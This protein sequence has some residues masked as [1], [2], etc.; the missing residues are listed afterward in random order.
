M[1]QSKLILVLSSILIAKESFFFVGRRLATNQGLVLT[2]KDQTG[3]WKIE[4][5]VAP[6]EKVYSRRKLKIRGRRK[7]TETTFEKLL[8]FISRK[9]VPHE[10]TQSSMQLIYHLRGVCCKNGGEIRVKFLLHL[11]APPVPRLT[12]PS[13]PARSAIL[14]AW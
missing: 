6:A 3:I 2:S 7:Y 12:S 5:R 9:V 13:S 1:R 14:R 4:K 11:P 10:I 8:V